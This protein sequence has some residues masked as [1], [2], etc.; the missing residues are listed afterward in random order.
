M[1]VT[2]V[3]APARHVPLDRV[4]NLR[5][6]GG[7][8]AEDGR[9]VAWG[10]LYRSD[11]LAPLAGRDL[12]M[13]RSLGLR[14]VLDLRTEAERDEG[15]F[16]VRA[17]P[18]DL[19]HVPVLTRTW[20]EEEV[21]V[22]AA[23]A[24]RATPYLVAR[25][26][27]MLEEGGPALA[28]AVAIMAEPVAQPLVFHCAA[29]KDR[30]GVLAALV[31]SLLGVSPDDIVGDYASSADAMARRLAWLQAT[32]PAA[33]TAMTGRPAGWLAAPPEAMH[34]L[35]GHLR[36]VHDGPE[37]YLAAHGVDRFTFDLLR[38]TLLV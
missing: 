13:V 37:G 36:E 6:L 14:T 23:V 18:L 20:H 11:D 16:P 24:D 5:D 35:L 8:Q 2:D 3:R 19:H 9:T 10:R 27:D 7:Y 25:Y 15:G 26:I 33:A 32:E 17:H 31:L 12:D 22:L 28:A 1:S 34:A 38:S 21:D 4:F 29:G 30:T